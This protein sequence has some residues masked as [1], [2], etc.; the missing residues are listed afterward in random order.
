[1]GPTWGVAMNVKTRNYYGT[2]Y[3]GIVMNEKTQQLLWDPIC[4]YC[5][6][7]KNLETIMR[8]SLRV[9]H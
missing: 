6:E 1:M 5:N 2:L 3:V 7:C 8:S 4:E 9:L